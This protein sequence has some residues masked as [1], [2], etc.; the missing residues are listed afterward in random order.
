MTDIIIGTSKLGWILKTYKL[1]KILSVIDHQLKNNQDIH[2]SLSYGYSLHYL[3]KCKNLD[4]SKSSFYIKASFNNVQDFLVEIF[5]VCKIIGE[6]K[7][8]NIQINEFFDIENIDKLNKAID[9]IKLNLN[10]KN[11]YLTVLPH[12]YKIF[13]NNKKTTKFNY[14]IH[15][16]LIENHIN[17]EFFIYCKKNK[18]KILALRALGGGINNFKY[19]DFTNDSI[20]FTKSDLMNYNHM[21]SKNNISQIEARA[22]FV[23]SNDLLEKIVISTSCIDNLK[24]LIK[25]NNSN[26]SKFNI[27][28]LKKLSKHYFQGKM[29]KNYF[30]NDKNLI[31]KM[32]GKTYKETYLSLK[33][34]G[35]ITNQYLLKCIIFSIIYMGD[36]ILHKLKIKF[37]S[38]RLFN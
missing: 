4:K 27:K 23:L 37:I 29:N 28:I 19:N 17:D 24:K 25:I 18:K 32:Y 36:F 33:K 8:I 1:Q 34:R 35:L 2:L 13:I 22:F 26:I 16:S 5:Y 15:Y 20:S 3:K 7:M 14:A 12:N 11:I 21:L 9:T 31:N 30:L 6:S 10:L 38:L